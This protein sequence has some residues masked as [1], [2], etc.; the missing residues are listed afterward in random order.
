M[1][2]VISWRC[3]AVP[4]EQLSTGIDH[5]PITD[6]RD[7]RIAP[8]PFSIDAI[9]EV[10]KGLIIEFVVRDGAGRAAVRQYDLSWN[11]H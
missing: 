3:H 10:V 8:D 6:G 9:A 2:D 4:V 1:V 5:R 7:M 11:S